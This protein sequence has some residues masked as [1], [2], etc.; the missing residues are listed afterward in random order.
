MNVSGISN[1]IGAMY[2]N[3][4]SGKKDTEIKKQAEQSTAANVTKTD[5]DKKNIDALNINVSAGIF[6]DTDVNSMYQFINELL[7]TDD[8]N[9]NTD[10]YGKVLKIARR[11]AKGDKVPAYDEKKLMEYSMDLYQM[12]KASA[13]LHA[14]EKHKKHK[15]L[16]KDEDKK[17][18]IER[19]IQAIS[20]DQDGSI[21]KVTDTD[22]TDLP[23]DT[24]E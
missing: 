7:T 15:S 14:N 11:I 16:Y 20:D 17:R 23:N 4:M 5:N 24:T 2:M 6:S 13:M 18:D 10:D 22:D 9:K 8:N 12:A 19:M 3:Q 21:I 1:N